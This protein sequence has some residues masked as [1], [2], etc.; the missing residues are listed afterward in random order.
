MKNWKKKIVL[1]IA[2]AALMATTLVGC[3]RT[4]DNTAVVSVVNGE[5]ITLG[6]A[7]FYSRNQQLMLESWY[8]QMMGLEPEDM[9]T[10]PLGP[11]E[12]Y[13]T[14]TLETLISAL[15]NLVIVRQH[16]EVYGVSLTEAQLANIHE[17]AEA[18]NLANSEAAIEA[19]SGQPMYVREVL[20]LL[21]IH[22]LMQEPMRAGADE[23]VADEEALQKA[24][25]YVLFPFTVVD[26]EGNRTELEG[27]ERE[28]LLHT[29]NEL[30]YAVAASESHDMHEAAEVFEVNVLTNSFDEESVFVPEEV[31]AAAWAATEEWQVLDVIETAQGYYVVKVTSLLDREATDARIASI[32]AERQQEQLDNRMETW[33][34][35]S[36]ISRNDRVLRRIDLAGIGLTVII[37]EEIT[38]EDLL[39]VTEEADDHETANADNNTDYNYTEEEQEETVETEE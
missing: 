25:E 29:A 17:V 27:A 15:E 28:E 32:I 30:A 23:E 2:G 35:E 9:W 34:E 38:E 24:M 19:V 7:N 26:D 20:E 14:S 8:S 31:I 18:F 39:D 22:T 13:E 16:A 37:P 6:T 21:T 4:L 10:M 3:N 33:R 36:E 1:F 5:E 12:T 11:G